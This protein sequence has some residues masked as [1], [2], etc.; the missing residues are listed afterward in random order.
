MHWLASLALYFGKH[1]FFFSIRNAVFE[2]ERMQYAT[3]R[4]EVKAQ[5]IG[6]IVESFALCCLLPVLAFFSLLRSCVPRTISS[7]E[8]ALRFRRSRVTKQT[9]LFIGG[10]LPV[11]FHPGDL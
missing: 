10:I 1:R 8:S 3:T 4:N 7:V 11:P 6:C 9:F 2:H 5:V